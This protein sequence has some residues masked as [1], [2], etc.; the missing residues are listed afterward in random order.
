MQAIVMMP[1]KC[2]G[3]TWHVQAQIVT[4][5]QLLLFFAADAKLSHGSASQTAFSGWYH[6]D[7]QHNCNIATLSH[8]DFW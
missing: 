6:A 3:D 2:T 4:S 8:L 5:Q 1:A 7:P